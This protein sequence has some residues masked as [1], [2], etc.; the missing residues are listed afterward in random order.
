[1][2]PNYIDIIDN[3][4]RN[5]DEIQ[6]DLGEK[7]SYE[8]EMHET[9][10]SELDT[11]KIKFDDQHKD[12]ISKIEQESTLT[13]RIEDLQNKNIQLNSHIETVLNKKEGFEILQHT[14][15]DL[16]LALISKNDNKEL[17]LRQKNLIRD[18][19]GDSLLKAIT[20]VN[21]KY[22]NLESESNKVTAAAKSQANRN[23]ML[24]KIAKRYMLAVKDC[25]NLYRFIDLDNLIFSNEAQQNYFIKHVN[26]VLEK[27]ESEVKQLLPQIDDYSI[28][29][30]DD[31]VEIQRQNDSEDLEKYC[32]MLDSS[33][34]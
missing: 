25:T 26:E 7:Y 18:L 22:K 17:T 2:C 15:A 6:Q 5:R 12:L 34:M 27:Y 11:L 9:Y 20:T 29:I 21:D 31:L 28:E 1:M 19:F 8:K 3:I 23:K 16:S 24:C 14:V 32:N 33:R 30:Q 10:K 4:R 13:Q